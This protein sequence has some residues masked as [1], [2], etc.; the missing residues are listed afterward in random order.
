[1]VQIL[2]FIS[3]FIKFLP[4][5]SVYSIVL[6]EYLYTAP[7][8][9]GLSHHQSS[10]TVDIGAGSSF[11]SSGWPPG[12]GYRLGSTYVKYIS[13]VHSKDINMH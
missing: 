4:D 8:V 10:S 2:I 12:Y 5:M 3:Y 1:M 7:P 13:M 6:S 9:F 11:P